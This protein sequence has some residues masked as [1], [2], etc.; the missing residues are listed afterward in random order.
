[1]NLEL[2]DRDR[3]YIEDVRWV[4][5]DVLKLPDNYP[6]Y[7]IDQCEIFPIES[8]AVVGAILSARI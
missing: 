5:D 4:Q 8:S 6:P 3:R 2:D 1:M 7:P